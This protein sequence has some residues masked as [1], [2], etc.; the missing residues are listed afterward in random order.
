MC[1]FVKKKCVLSLIAFYDFALVAKLHYLCNWLCQC[2][3]IV[4]FGHDG[5]YKTDKYDKGD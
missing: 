5:Y 1:H 3:F 4:R 2:G